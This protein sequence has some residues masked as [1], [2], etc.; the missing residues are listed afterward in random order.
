[1]GRRHYAGRLDQAA[2]STS[3]LIPRLFPVGPLHVF[4]RDLLWPMS[5][6]FTPNVLQLVANQPVLMVERLQLL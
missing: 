4:E 1:M 5:F 2:H 3:R 6:P